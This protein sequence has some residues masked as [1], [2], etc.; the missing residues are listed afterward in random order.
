MINNVLFNII[1]ISPHSDCDSDVELKGSAST[2]LMKSVIGSKS[3]NMPFNLG[4]ILSMA[5]QSGGMLSAQGN[6]PPLVPMANNDLEMLADLDIFS[7]MAAK[8]ESD[9]Q[10]ITVSLMFD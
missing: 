4:P 8:S 7:N 5:S 1:I 9:V 6:T 10:Q 3:N 2:S